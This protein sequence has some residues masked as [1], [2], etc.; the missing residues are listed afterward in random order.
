MIIFRA[1]NGVGL[2][3]VQ[4]LLFSLIADKSGASGRGRAFGFLLCTG[5]LDWVVEMGVAILISAG[6][7]ESVSTIIW[8][9]AKIY[10]NGE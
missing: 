8:P 10:R 6:K 1:V 5:D 9:T 4:P 2:G 3:I 7:L